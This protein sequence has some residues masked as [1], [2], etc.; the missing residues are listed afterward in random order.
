M[1]VTSADRLGSLA[2]FSGG[3]VGRW[4]AAF[5]L[6]FAAALVQTWPLA[7][8]ATDSII[9]YRAWPFDSWDFLWNLWWV[10]HA[11]VELHANPYQTD[12][13]YYPGGTEL[14]LHTL[15]PVIGVLSIPL[16]LATGNLILSWNLLIIAFFVASALGMYA[17]SYK[18]TGNHWAALISGYIFAFAP[19]FLLK[20]IGQ[21]HLFMT[22][23]IPLIVLFLIRFQET[24]R[25]REAAAAGILWSVLTYNTLEY[26]AEAGLF[27]GLFLAYWSFVYLRKKDWPRLPP[28]WRGIALTAGVWLLASLPLL[29]PTIRSVYGG[30]Y[31]LSG[32]DEYFSADLLGYV[33]PS[34]LWGSGVAPE[35]PTPEKSPIGAWETTVFLG[36]TPLILAGLALFAV[37]RT[38]QRVILWSVVFLLFATLALG[39][40]LYVGNTKSLSLLGAS[41]TVPLPY[42]IYDRLPLVSV[43]RVPARMIVFALVGLAVLAGTGFDVLTSWLRPKYRVLTPLVAAVVLGFLVFEYWNPPVQLS[44]ITAPAIFQEIRDEQG[45]FSVLHAPWGRLTG[46]T[47]VGFQAGGAIATYYGRIHEKPTFGGYLSRVPEDAFSPGPLGEEAGLGYLACTSCLEPRPPDLNADEARQVLR[48]YKIR[49]VVLHRADPYGGAFGIPIENLQAMDDYIR[50]VLGLAPVFSDSILTV[51]RNDQIE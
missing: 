45:D 43:G 49:Y 48:R 7:L 35:L 15:A 4:S 12:Y 16:Q 14:Y 1:A 37:R 13:V 44:E 38:P 31:S 8:H 24:G 28:L 23:P 21:G 2:R 6:F 18:I 42:Q 17:L 26:G 46:Q 19:F 22:W 11:L 33:T 9:D 51:Y 32:Q 5:F 36:I 25:L 29:I 47:G 30:E 39:P 40:Y 41:F 10:R 20:V 3:A 27:L 34:P 50:T